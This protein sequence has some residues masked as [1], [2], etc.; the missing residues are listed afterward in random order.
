[1]TKTRQL[2]RRNVSFG[3]GLTILMHNSV[4]MDEQVDVQSSNML[5]M[6]PQWN[7]IHGG[8]SLLKGQRLGSQRCHISGCLCVTVWCTDSQSHNSQC[9]FKLKA[10][11]AHRWTP[12]CWLSVGLL[13]YNMCCLLCFKIQGGGQM[14][15]L[16]ILV[17]IFSTTLKIR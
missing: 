9:H 7:A 2:P 3:L 15:I 6:S 10:H 16:K 14:A 1:M 4:I 5:Q 12:T 8:L 11:I 13:L 17:I